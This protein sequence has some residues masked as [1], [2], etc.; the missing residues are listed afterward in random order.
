MDLATTLQENETLLRA[1]IEERR[2]VMAVYQ[3]YRRWLCPHL[4]GYKGNRLHLLAYQYSGESASGAIAT[5]PDPEYGPPENW[6][7]LD[8]ARIENLAVLEAGEWYTSARHTR[9]QTCIYHVIAGV[10]GFHG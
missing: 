2:P 8:V 1:A 10:R 3:G 4:L 9:R 5:P 6:R 7:C